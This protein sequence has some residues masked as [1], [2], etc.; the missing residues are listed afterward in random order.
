MLK[1]YVLFLAVK[2]I[3]EHYTRKYESPEVELPL[4][5][6]QIKIQNEKSVVNVPKKLA[7]RIGPP[8]NTGKS[9]FYET[10]KKKS[11]SPNNY[12]SYSE[13]KNSST[14]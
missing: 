4:E 6:V 10:L 7:H 8:N 3:L 2:R 13:E 5:K 11:K 9:N 1:S 12:F 14:N